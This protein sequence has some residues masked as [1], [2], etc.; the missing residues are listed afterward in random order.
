M[1]GDWIPICDDL[2]R[3]TQV[4]EIAEAT[5]RS[6]DEVVGMLVRLWGW[7]VREADPETGAVSVRS[8]SGLC[9]VVVPAMSDWDAIIASGWCAYDGQTLAFAK[10]DKWLSKVAKARVLDT[11]RKRERRVN[12]SGCHPDKTRTRDRDRD[13]CTPLPPRRGDGA[14]ASG[15]RRRRQREAEAA[16]E[17]EDRR[18]RLAAEARERVPPGVRVTVDGEGW[19]S[20]GP[21]AYGE[22]SG[23]KP[24]RSAPQAVLR[25]LLAAAAK[26]NGGLREE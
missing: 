16:Q 19:V 20:E 7:A 14:R 3:R 22:R 5:G 15:S 26:E 23:F 2:H 12:V 1:A 8:L 9:P 10:W 21:G 6:A 17:E 18:A 25:A 4:L 24:W 13:R 11:L